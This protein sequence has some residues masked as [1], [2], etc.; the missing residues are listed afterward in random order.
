MAKKKKSE[1]EIFTN[2]IL[3]KGKYKKGWDWLGKQ[4]EFARQEAAN[5]KQRV[6]LKSAGTGKVYASDAWKGYTD[7]PGGQRLVISGTPSAVQPD[8]KRKMTQPTDV[9]KPSYLVSTPLPS[10]DTSSWTSEE[11]PPARDH[12]TISDIADPTVRDTY[13]RLNRNIWGNTGRVSGPEDLLYPPAYPHQQAGGKHWSEDVSRVNQEPRSKNS[14]WVSKMVLGD[15]HPPSSSIGYLPNRQSVGDAWTDAM[16]HR[17]YNPDIYQ[18]RNPVG[19]DLWGRPVTQAQADRV[20]DL[21]PNYG[22][23]RRSYVFG[24]TMAP[25]VGSVPLSATAVSPTFRPENVNKRS[26]LN[27]GNIL[28]RMGR[29]FQGIDDRLERNRINRLMNRTNNP[30]Y[31]RGLY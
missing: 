3:G 31:G 5:Q 8:L 28:N 22:D 4:R 20:T 1:L 11:L 6:P 29:T 7:K 12:R 18:M 25:G 19:E 17:T 13:E 9:H 30:Y 10:V 2:M 15:Q 23:P 16:R 26:L 14:G 21:Q 24:D 27:M